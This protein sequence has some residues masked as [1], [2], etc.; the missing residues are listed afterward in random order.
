[1]RMRICTEK[2]GDCVWI[3]WYVI[4]SLIS[5]TLVLCEEILGEEQR[6]FRS[7]RR[8]EFLFLCRPQTATGTAWQS[9]RTSSD[10]GDVRTSFRNLR[11]QR[12]WALP[13]F[14]TKHSC[15][16]VF[17]DPRNIFYPAITPLDVNIPIRLSYHG[18]SHYNS[19]EYQLNSPH[20]L[21]YLVRFSFQWLIHLLQRWV[22]GWDFLGITRV[23]LIIWETQWRKAKTEV[24]NR[25]CLRV[26]SRW[27]TSK[28]Q[29][30]KSA[31]RF[32]RS[33]HRSDRRT[34]VSRCSRS[35][36]TR[37]WNTWE[38]LL[39]RAILLWRITTVSGKFWLIFL[40]FV[41][42]VAVGDSARSVERSYV[43]EGSRTGLYE[44]L[45]ALEGI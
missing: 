17:S 38:W 28:E 15:V 21:L 37:T 29:R 11:I 20:K 33:L 35:P 40:S 30:K 26:N 22:W 32:V 12:E 19:G 25:R 9:R 16:V 4:C 2:S 43:N 24:W 23:E 8:R 1:M 27:Q 39:V 42:W 36:E 45:L 13:I 34:D 6:P 41:N 18:S 5:P 14:I 31:T 3:T 44:E 7:L 10:L